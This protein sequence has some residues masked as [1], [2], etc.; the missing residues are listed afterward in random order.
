MALRARF[1]LCG[2]VP[3]VGDKV[4][5]RLV[6][7]PNPRIPGRHLQTTSSRRDRCQ[8]VRKGPNCLGPNED[9]LAP[10]TTSLFHKGAW[11]N[12]H[13]ICIFFQ[14]AK[15]TQQERSAR[16]P[17]PRGCLGRAARPHARRHSPGA[18]PARA[19][20]ATAAVTGGTPAWWRGRRLCRLPTPEVPLDWRGS[21]PGKGEG[22]A[23]GGNL[24]AREGAGFRPRVLV[25]WARARAAAARA[26]AGGRGE[27]SGAGR[28]AAPAAAH[29]EAPHAAAAEGLARRH[30]RHGVDAV[31]VLAQGLAVGV[32]AVG[33]WAVGFL[34]VWLLAVGFRRLDWLLAVG[35]RV[36]GCGRSRWGFGFWMGRARRAARGRALRGRGR[37]RVGA[38]PRG[39][40]QGPHLLL[41]LV[42]QR[43]GEVG[44]L[45]VCAAQVA[46][47]EHGALQDG[48]LQ[49][50]LVEHGAARGRGAGAGG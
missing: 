1:A 45:Y 31:G 28:R 37:G 34:G 17:R 12:L 4:L 48:V 49:V 33:V 3:S 20:A 24:G 39:A 15:L 26:F 32:Q 40:G 14:Q 47:R 29:P 16:A 19:A 10:T 7:A 11:L 30:A 36:L 44:A 25:S 8:A 9:D 22:E 2:L 35:F 6:K 42:H 43:V 38:G 50:G 5:N 21:T 41:R 27:E 46:A 23:K 13:F 18:R